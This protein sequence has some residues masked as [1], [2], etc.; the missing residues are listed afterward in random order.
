MVNI[1]TLRLTWWLIITSFIFSACS[2]QKENLRDEKYGGTLRINASDVPDVIF[3]GR[4]LKSSEQLI[5]NQVYV[6]L[7]K[8]NARTL[9]I[10]ASLAKRW[11]AERNQ[12]LY[13]F[14]LF[15][16]AFFQK[17]DC[18]GQ[19]K[20]R[21]ITAQDVKYSIEHIAH[22][23]AINGHEL[24]LQLKNIIGSETVLDTINQTDSASISGIKVINDTTIVFEL[25][26]PDA[27][28]LHY[29][30]N[31]NG[32]V[33]PHEAFDTYGYNSTVGS[34]PFKFTYPAIKGQKMILLANRDFFGKNKQNQVLPFIDTLEVSFITSP[35]KELI[36]FE[37]G[38]LD[39]V[40]GV[41]GE[42]VT[43]FMDKH[44][45]EFQSNPPYYIMK[46]TA[47]KYNNVKYNFERANVRDL[48]LNV[49]GY[50]DFS[51]VYFKEPVEQ[52]IKVY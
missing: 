4:V 14:F 6:G 49:I 13:T 9:N 19:T 18:F 16:N 24:S 34:G 47:D 29:L 23:H 30:A 11:R 8:Y 25:K 38:K 28:F 33:Y 40:V 41:S 35:P 42:Y 44:I 5:I 45:D 48:E 20:I 7:V 2:F 1:Q 15:N 39:L 3:P 43:D 26:E 52:E 46:Q 12:T 37:Q 27:L 10:E 51:Q 50:F 32:L 21:K 31:T 36:F 22:Y 17:D